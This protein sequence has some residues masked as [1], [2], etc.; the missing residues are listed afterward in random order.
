VKPSMAD[1]D[2]LSFFLRRHKKV[3]ENFQK[4]FK[5]IGQINLSIINYYEL[6]GGLKH[7]DAHNKLE[8][9]QTIVEKNTLL[10]L[11]EKSCE[12]ATDIYAS[13]RKQG[14]PLD[15]MDILIASI[16]IENELVLVTH[17]RKNFE[18]LKNLEIEDW[19]IF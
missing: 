8:I 18:R 3:V 9:F 6:L 13:L 7:K 19:S 17:N 1:T 14:N 16:A 4:Y 5:E 2:T 15:D 10:P 12:I 11:T